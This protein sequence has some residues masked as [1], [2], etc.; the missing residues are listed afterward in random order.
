MN[1]LNQIVR[2]KREEILQQKIKVSETDLTFHATFQ[3]NCYSLSAFLT[4]PESSG[5]IAEFKRKSP[6]K[7][8]IQRS[9]D[10]LHITAAYA[11]SGA[12]ALSVLT[13]ADFFGGHQSDLSG[14]RQGISIP[15]LRK[16]FIIDPY[17]IIEAKSLGADVI[18]LIAEIL[19]KQE[20][21]AFSKL[22]EACG[23]EVL[24]EVHTKDQLKKYHPR[25]QH[26]GVNNRNLKTFTT[27]IS[28]SV[29]MLPHLPSETTKVAESGLHDVRDVITLMKA[30][31][32]G[33]LIGE[34]FMKTEDPGKTCADFIHQINMLK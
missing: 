26:I 15:I 32:Q 21:D 25:I 23:M 1:I 24:L 27:D 9:A 20:I 6:S 8:N 19:H 5:I 13:D 34:C 10:V 17:Q 3:R 33:F 14:I 18:L 11:N 16:D 29:N 2:R 12:C 30:G 31:Y 4:S 28:S 22:A 7:P